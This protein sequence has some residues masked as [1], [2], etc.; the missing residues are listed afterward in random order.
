MTLMVLHVRQYSCDG[1]M[2]LQDARGPKFAEQREGKRPEPDRDWRQGREWAIDWPGSASKEEPVHPQG[3]PSGDLIPNGGS[4][5]YG[6]FPIDAGTHL[7]NGSAHRKPV[8]VVCFRTPVEDT[9]SRCFYF[10][11]LLFCWPFYWLQRTS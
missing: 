9:R 11:A 5:A 4:A 3:S 2:T 7:T 1:G 6:S 10:A 8:A